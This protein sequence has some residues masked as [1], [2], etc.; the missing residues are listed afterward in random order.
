MPCRLNLIVKVQEAR[1]PENLIQI[2]E[3]G[4]AVY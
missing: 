3:L 1:Y 2:T 4:F